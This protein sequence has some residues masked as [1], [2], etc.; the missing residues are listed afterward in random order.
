MGQTM[1]IGLNPKGR[2][3]CDDTLNGG[4]RN[5]LGKTGLGKRL[6]EKPAIL[7]ENGETYLYSIAKWLVWK[8][9]R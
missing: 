1:S 5:S 7:A 9:C 6:L 4:D 3:H 2:P 8:K